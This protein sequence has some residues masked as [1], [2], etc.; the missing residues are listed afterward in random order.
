M[1]FV[2][3][4]FS[5]LLIV[6]SSMVLHEVTHGLVAYWLGDDTAKLSGR[7]TLN[8]FR[9][10]DPFLTIG[11]PLLLALGSFLG[12]GLPIFGG[13]KPVPI[14][15]TRVRG[16]ELGFA[17][18]ALSGPLTNFVL[19]FLFFALAHFSSGA[20]S[21]FAYLAVQINLGFMIFNL[22]PIPPLDGS[23]VVYAIAP[24]FVRR[25]MESLER[26]GIMIVFLLIMFLGGLFGLLMISLIDMIL[27]WFTWIFGLI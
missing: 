25:A 19:A 7:L 21:A 6:F 10:I 8:P 26:Y 24:D 14:N 15:T 23:R 3:Y 20:L 13:A 5:V 11:M 4:I 27:G 17:A 16:G 12:A 18:V 9:H 1:D 2:I 22:L